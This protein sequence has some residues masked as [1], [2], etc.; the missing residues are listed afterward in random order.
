MEILDLWV[1]L[2]LTR[3]SKSMVVFEL[4]VN[5]MEGQCNGPDAVVNIAIKFVLFNDYIHLLSAAPVLARVLVSHLEIFEFRRGCVSINLAAL[6][7][8]KC[9]LIVKN[10]PFPRWSDVV[11]W[12]RVLCP[13]LCS[14]P[15]QLAALAH[16]KRSLCSCST[17]TVCLH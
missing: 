9:S 7:T 12:K 4:I 11:I 17:S 3:F 2:A 8:I 6:S 1:K 16:C 14:R 5:T 10:S 15:L 13:L